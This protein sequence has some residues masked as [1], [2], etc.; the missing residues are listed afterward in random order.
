MA[1]T[2]PIK[3]GATWPPL[4]ATLRDKK[5]PINLVGADVFLR[6]RDAADLG[7]VLLGGACLNLDDG[8]E[9]NRGKIEYQW[10]TVDTETPG[11]YRIEFKVVF[12]PG[13]LQER[14]TKIPNDDYDLIEVVA[15]V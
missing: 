10:L 3:E 6:M 8:T 2:Y 12:A 13:T 11:V 4:R 9:G 5:G 15:E 1:R 14:V 7:D